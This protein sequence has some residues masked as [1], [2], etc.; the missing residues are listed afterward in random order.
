MR[1]VAHKHLTEDV[2]EKII[3]GQIEAAKKGD[4][5]AIKFVFDQLMGGAAFKG[6][7]F[8]QHN[9]GS[10]FGEQHAHPTAARP[11][12]PDKLAVMRKRIEN[13][14]STTQAGDAAVPA[15]ECSNCGN[16]VRVK[17]EK[18]PKCGHFTF[19]PVAA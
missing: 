4:R 8:I 3:L 13:G 17:P 7:T 16:A 1:D 10:E 2:V 15:W 6:A 5:N 14:Q 19:V 11:G 18:C 12:T 9:Y